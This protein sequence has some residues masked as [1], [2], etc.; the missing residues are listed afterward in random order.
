MS[1]YD[2][3]EQCVICGREFSEDESSW[4]LHHL[5]PK[6]KGGKDSE[7]IK[8]HRICHN[9]I[10]STWAENELKRYYHTVER[11]TSDDRMQK[12][13]KWVRRKPSDFYVKT[14]DTSRRRN[15]R[16]R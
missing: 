7:L 2:N 15:K 6:S 10:H 14:K 4:D 5:I 3:I 13:I 16:R 12:F 1:I 9:T 11:I 8:I